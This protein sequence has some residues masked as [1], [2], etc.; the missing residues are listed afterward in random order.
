MFK[1]QLVAM[2]NGLFPLPMYNCALS[3][4]SLDLIAEAARGSWLA[5]LLEVQSMDWG[6]GGGG[7]GAW[8]PAQAPSKLPITLHTGP[9]ICNV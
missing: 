9:C 8:E 3:I 7:G 1:V 5:V 4:A 2:C 6:G